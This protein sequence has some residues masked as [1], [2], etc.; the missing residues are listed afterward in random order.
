MKGIIAYLFCLPAR[1]FFL[2]ARAEDVRAEHTS[3]WQQA[4]NN[5][6]V[7]VGHEQVEDS[8]FAREGDFAHDLILSSRAA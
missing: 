1:S 4:E 3:A 6:L 5:H 2:K 7:R 8:R